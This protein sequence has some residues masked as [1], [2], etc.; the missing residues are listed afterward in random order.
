MKWITAVLAATA[1]LVWDFRLA[2]KVLAAGVAVSALV[3]WA[4]WYFEEGDDGS[5]RPGG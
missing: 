4:L 1:A 3:K 5:N 2:W